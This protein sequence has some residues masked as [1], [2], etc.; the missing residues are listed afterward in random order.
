MYL[1]VLEVIILGFVVFIIA[2]IIFVRCWL[3]RSSGLSNFFIVVLERLPDV[4]WSTPDA[5][6]HH[7]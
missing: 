2:P 1:V 3:E 6:S 4:P 7:D 5:E